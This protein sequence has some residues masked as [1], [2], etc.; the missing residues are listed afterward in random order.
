[1]E[2]HVSKQAE[3]MDGL[4]RK[5]HFKDEY[6]NSDIL[7]K[8]LQIKRNTPESR[9]AITKKFSHFLELVEW[10]GMEIIHVF[11]K[12]TADRIVVFLHGGAYIHELNAGH[13][14]YIQELASKLKADVYAPLYPLAPKHEC[15]ESIQL[16]DRFLVEILEKGEETILMGDSAGGGMAVSVCQLLFEKKE[17]LPD[18]IV[19]FSPWLD[20]TDS[21]QEEKFY[22]ESDP[23]LSIEGLRTC[24]KE[25]AGRLSPEDPRVSPF[26]GE[27]S[28]LPPVLMFCGGNE[29][30]YPTIIQFHERLTA[31]GVYCKLVT[32]PGLFHD[33]AMYPIPEGK[34]TLNTVAA[35]VQ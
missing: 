3:L 15:L 13:L 14:V 23:V 29:L 27:T 32:A 24:G 21:N 16:V 22:E 19:L 8:V 11:P 5:M 6:S 25:W 28:F 4:L 34:A 12:D 9:F 7:N 35:F 33:Y 26:F 30:F 2:V 10:K 1:M 18:R 17:K 20:V 31:E